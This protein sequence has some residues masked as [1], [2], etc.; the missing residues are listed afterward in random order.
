MK[1][2]DHSIHQHAQKFECTK[3]ELFRFIFVD[4]IKNFMGSVFFLGGGGHP[5]L[6]VGGFW[7]Q[8]NF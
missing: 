7:E 1:N 3:L 8:L 2:W 4:V 6:P 5:V